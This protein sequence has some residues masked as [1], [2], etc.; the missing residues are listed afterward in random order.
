MQIFRIESAGEY[1]MIES[2]YEKRGA[3]KAGCIP[4]E[5]GKYM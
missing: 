5:K 4:A 1:D 3:K 2:G